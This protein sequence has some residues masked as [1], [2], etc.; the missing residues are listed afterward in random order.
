MKLSR[1]WMIAIGCLAAFVCVV[2][3]GT[4]ALGAI[5]QKQ[6]ETAL[7]QSIITGVPLAP[8]QVI[9]Q[10]NQ[11]PV[12]PGFTLGDM[13][14]LIKK[15]D[16]K[17]CEKSDELTCISLEMPLDHFDTNNKKTITVT[18]GIH[19]AT[20]ERKGMFFQAFPGGPGGEGI[21]SSAFR[22]DKFDKLIL[23]HYDIVFF[24][25]RGLGL[26]SPLTCPNALTKDRT[27]HFNDYDK[28]SVEGYDTPQEQKDLITQDKT[29]VENCVK[30][31]GVAPEELK[32]YNTK[33]VAEDIEA[34][35]AAVGDEKF[36]LY[37][38][39]YGTTVA[40]IY[41]E[42][43]AD[44]LAGMILDGTVDLTQ[45][46][47]GKDHLQEKG[48]DK[49]L[50][51]TLKACGEDSECSSD[52]NGDDPLKVYDD[53][54]ASLSKKPQDVNFTLPD[55][56][57]AKRLMTFNKLE[58]VSAYAMY[59]QAGRT[60]YLRSLAAA[61][62]GDFQPLLRLL[63]ALLDYDPATE[64]WIGDPTF[65]DTAFYMVNCLDDSYFSGTPDERAQAVIKD[66][67]ASNGT[68]PRLDGGVYT[69]VTCAYWPDS[70]QKD[71]A[72]PPLKAEGVPVIV[73][74][75]TLD[76]ATPF[77]GGKAVYSRLADGYHI[78]VDG[79]EHGVYLNEE[80]CPDDYITNFLVYG[81]LP[82]QHEVK[83]TWESPVMWAYIKPAP[84]NA[85]D[86]PNL[87][88]GLFYT[89]V[90]ILYSPEHL[91][92]HT[93]DKDIDVVCP[94]GGKFTFN[95]NQKAKTEK[96]T[97]SDCSFSKGFAMTGTGDFNT[98][99][100]N[101]TYEFDVKG[102]KTGHLTYKFTRDPQSIA[103]NGTY[104]GETIDIQR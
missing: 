76:P 18:F 98:D 89:D 55:G 4:I 25:Q 17:P 62:R 58:N 72:E 104:G 90:D 40:Q 8:T 21:S 31:M 19:P 51:A 69:G 100:G 63:Y 20:G 103:I 33:Q 56:T 66:G 67:Q 23:E 86:F 102:P 65:S 30:E 39:S 14:A 28:D 83:C 68:V 22:I 29:F 12:T 11:T 57:T 60:I 74:N 87:L 81:K 70:P 59:S 13:Q 92:N 49:V 91:F 6:I 71:T 42:S 54:A 26:S 82:A 15:Q 45:D 3:I 38:V 94:Y 52:F 41:A 16:G 36:F 97:F 84:A 95:Y 96:F 46:G 43:H 93:N 1:N 2:C 7:N 35:R 64:K 10:P 32:F 75:A 24:D 44:H 50:V 73:L 101:R 53:M 78:Y 99:T 61:H 9:I 77:D 5:Y 34:F 80:K 27:D 37:G 79:G 47:P 48:F 88:A 85:S